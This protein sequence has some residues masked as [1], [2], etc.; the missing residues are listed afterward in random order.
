[1]KS[2]FVLLAAFVVFIL[3][4]TE[5]REQQF[6]SNL[7]HVKYFGFSLIDVYFDD[8]TDGELKDNYIDEVSPFSNIGDLLVIDPQEDISNRVDRFLE[9]DMKLFIYVTELFFEVE[10]VYSPSGVDYKLR[11]D[12]ESRWKTF[13][14][15]NQS[16]ITEEF[17]AAFYLGEEPTWNGITFEELQTAADLITS[18]VADV[19]IMI[20]EAYP[21]IDD[22][23][24]PAS[25]D[26]VG[27][28]HYFIKSPISDSSFQAELSVLQSKMATHQQLVLVMDSHY[29]PWAHGDF[30]G[31]ELQ[32]I[33]EVTQDYI[34]IAEKNK[35]VVTIIG[36]HWPN[37]F[38]FSET[39][40]A[41]NMP[42]YVMDL[43]RDIGAQITNK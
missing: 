13:L 30:G 1:M 16:V 43:Y 15:T 39:I 7:S 33:Q 28:N 42:S 10:G 37:G 23:E 21:V 29:I 6:T 27:F 9:N 5:D 31:I 40:G 22:L 25:V 19:P 14:S 35:N 12:Y 24:I 38:E 2:F 32:E 17:I 34:D 41:R 11:D 8:P 3:S 20:I 4:C 36:Y 18:D 26:W